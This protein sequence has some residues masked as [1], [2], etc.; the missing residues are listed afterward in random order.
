MGSGVS[1]FEIQLDEEPGQNEL[2]P[3][4]AGSLLS[5]KIVAELAKFEV[6]SDLAAS[7]GSSN[8]VRHAMQLRLYGKE[9]VRMNRRKSSKMNG[10]GRAQKCA[11][12]NVLDLRLQWPNFPVDAVTENGVTSVPAGTYV[13]PFRLQLPNTLPSSIYYPMHDNRK[14]SKLRF[15]IQYKMTAE[16]NL[17]TKAVQS[18]T[19][20]LWI[21]AAAPDP[22]QEPVPCMIEPVVHEI[23]GSLF[24]KGG[25]FLFCAA[26][27]DCCVKDALNLQVACRNN[28]SAE[29][30]NVQIKVLEK[31]TWGTV[32]VNSIDSETGACTKKPT[33]EQT[34]T[35]TLFVLRDIQ[36]PGLV[37]ERKSI[38][39]SALDSIIGSQQQELQRQIYQDLMSRENL[40]RIQLP[41]GARESYVGQLIQVSHFVRIE[42]QTGAFLKNPHVE[43]PIHIVGT[44]MPDTTQQAHQPAV[45]SG[46]GAAYRVSPPAEKLIPATT[47]VSTNTA[48]SEAVV[49]T[50]VSYEA[51]IVADGNKKTKSQIPMATARPLPI[52]DDAVEATTAS[53]D[54]VIVL[55]GDAVLRAESRRR[56]T[57]LV[58][59]APP[60]VDVSLQTLL[61]EMR[62]SINDFDL[63]SEK[64]LADEW[65]C[66]FQSLTPDEFGN[67][68]SRVHDEFDQPRV[69]MLIVP[70]LKPGLT[71]RHIVAA[72][73][74]TSDQHRA[75]MAQRLLPLCVDANANRKLI[76]AE[77]NEWEQTVVFGGSEVG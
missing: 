64:L 65:V 72:L 43:V 30:H 23:K 61:A 12:R 69:A 19:R 63:I 31:L 51:E 57:D 35:N 37:R 16:L 15:R 48:T 13:F 7:S 50:T 52:P 77:L 21:K 8:R 74:K 4:P 1:R 49:E 44:A 28:S 62:S 73:R 24:Q 3:L 38:L 29:I 54:D 55:G 46:A 68:I 26:V 67:I 32:A 33:L 60:S 17:G 2:L 70:H 25:V 39:K 45:A 42:F 40:I 9:K 58:P 36:L 20:Y 71:S 56:L 11:E 10:S 14:R 22:P 47:G 53:Y 5:G 27:D 6:P 34:D 66:L 18:V 76:I 75:V 41:V 59:L